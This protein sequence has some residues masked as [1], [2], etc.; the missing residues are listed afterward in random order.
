M[1]QERQ[2]RERSKVQQKLQTDKIEYESRLK[3]M[4]L[5][6]E[7]KEQQKRFEATEKSDE[8]LRREIELLILEKQRTEL[9]LAVNKP[10]NNLLESPD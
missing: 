6:A 3:G 1:A 5:E 9:M 8:Y 4:Q 10:A 7:I 2:Q